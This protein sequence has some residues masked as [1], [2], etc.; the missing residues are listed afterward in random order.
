M[1]SAKNVLLALTLVMIAGGL[2][3]QKKTTARD[4]FWSAGDLI[5]VTP[6]PAVHKHA[7]TP[8]HST[9]DTAATHSDS[10]S[11]D[12]VSAQQKNNSQASK[13]AQL[14]TD[15]G[16]GEAPHLVLA[17]EDRL[18]LRCSVMRRNPA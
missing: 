8:P 3:A 14:A 7:S 6:N 1:T 10:G 9:P 5:T 4:A 11:G 18:G 2:S 13:A 16:Y 15:N 17:S 12:E